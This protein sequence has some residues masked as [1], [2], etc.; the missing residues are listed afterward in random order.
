M[1]IK[2]MGDLDVTGNMN[3]TASDVPNLSAS[4]ITSGAF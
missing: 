3:I 1:A 4:K 2:L